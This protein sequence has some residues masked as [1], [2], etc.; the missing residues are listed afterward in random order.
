MCSVS[1]KAERMPMDLRQLRYAVELARTMHFTQAAER[2]GVAQ[3]AL[4]HSIALL[5]KDLGLPLF[6][7]TSRR[8]Q[9][10]AAGKYF[11]EQAGD[12]LRQ[13]DALQSD[14]R[15]H[16]RVLRGNV[17]VGTMAFFFLGEGY[18]HS[19][20]AEFAQIY[21][22]V[23]VTINDDTIG[24][25]LEGIR[26]GKVDVALLNLADPS[27]HP[28][29]NLSIIGSDEIAVAL[30]PGHRLA[31]RRRIR[32][33]DLVN[34]PFVVYEPGSMMHGVLASLARSA[35]F[36]PRVAVRSQSITLVRSLVSAGAGVSIGPTSYLASPGSPIV[37][38]P[39]IQPPSISITMVTHPSI[40]ANP[41][42]RAFISFLH[43]HFAV[44]Q[45][46]PLKYFEG[47]H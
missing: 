24:G 6:V 16:T 37:M 19:L 10:T 18:L 11:V 1:S 21:P 3:P 42:A 8:V 12:I 35:G 15:D 44:S 31:R 2:L 26:L 28:D 29:L 7:R 23:E 4:S 5:E 22:G 20:V 27:N 17:T 41:A 39:L 47:A 13:I 46:G 36:E 32:F 14:M 34:E 38:I 45:T 9:V 30:P 33:E 43:E 40:E 25:N